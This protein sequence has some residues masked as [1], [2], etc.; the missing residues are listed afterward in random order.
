[1]KVLV[2]IAKLYNSANRKQIILLHVALLALAGAVVYSNSLTVPF[3]LDDFFSIAFIGKQDLAG[4]MLHGTSRRVADI[5]FALNYR[6]HGLQVAGYHLV[7]VVIHLS[8]S[9]LLY[10]VM[11]SATTALRHSFAA[12]ESEA[13][14]SSVERFMPLVAALLFVCHPV[15]TQAVTYI[16]Q[17]YTSLAA[18]FYLLAVLLFLRGRL[19]LDKRGMTGKSAL[20]CGGTV[21]AG[22]L[23]I[24][25]KQI[26]VTLPAMLLLLEIF[27]FRGRLLNRRFWAGGAVLLGI[28]AAIV[29]YKWH[30]STFADFLF[31]L[32]HATAEDHFT[33]RT[34]YF[35]TQ[36]RVVLTYLRLLCL[37]LG[38]S[39]VHD[40]P[41]YSSVL[42]IPVMASLAVHALLAG[43]AAL[44][45]K[46]SG[47]NFQTG[48]PSRGVAQRLASL[49]ICWFYCA[50]AVES[51]VFPIIDVIFEH[52]I[53]LPSAGFFMTLA[54]L[55]AL[56][57]QSG[58]V[59]MKTAWALLVTVCLFLG[60]MT[61]ARN[62]VWNDSLALWREAVT[63]SP[64]KWL[65]Q[66]NL[67]GEYRSRRMPE[68]ALPHY[69][70]AIELN[71]NL[72]IQTK[73][74]LGD[75]LHDLNIYEGRFTTGKEYILSGGPYNSGAL[76]FKNM[77]GWDGVINNNMGLAYEYLRKPEAALKAYKMAVTLNPAYELA[78]YNLALLAA[79]GGDKGLADQAADRLER[80]NPELAK[81]V[82]A[83]VFH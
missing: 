20:L 17:R 55:V 14:T 15:Q 64:N 50:M 16:I 32:R 7:N 76:D 23:A 18:F 59:G 65:A 45:F 30:D 28:S 51:S 22:I 27:I 36:T 62:R 5:T 57:V 53:Y 10:F 46:M 74:N 34:T 78:W 43:C 40:S 52:R 1:V 29:L 19:A 83:A 37:P 48:N 54:A 11:A 44:L 79:R 33:S 49:G 13:E 77:F 9:M 68:K 41:A 70:R 82:K 81:A 56:A 80:L 26:A 71:P 25:S 63:E 24:G 60:G 6:L 47:S 21:V 69:V 35:L 58:R 42:A 38:Q 8:G 67:A 4:I 12:Q 2:G 72:F 66:A 39:L 73:V 75:V 3:I 31:D 61:I